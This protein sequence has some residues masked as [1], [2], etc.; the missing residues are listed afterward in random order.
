MKRRICCPVCMT[1]YDISADFMNRNMNCR[2]GIKLHIEA[3]LA[4]PTLVRADSG[5]RYLRTNEFLSICESLEDDPGEYFSIDNGRSWLPAQAIF[6]AM[7]LTCTIVKPAPPPAPEP[8][9]VSE[10][11][12][13][14]PP[15]KTAPLDSGF[16]L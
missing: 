14:S 4:R 2:C 13:P 7:R 9:P 1:E 15:S 16:S 10:P 6:D 5:I 12:P 3:M 8:Q 11:E